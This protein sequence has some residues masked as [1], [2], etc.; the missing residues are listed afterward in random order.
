MSCHIISYHMASYRIVMG[1]DEQGARG[2]V[3]ATKKCPEWA[4]CLVPASTAFFFRVFWEQPIIPMAHD[5]TGCSHG[6]CWH[7]SRVNHAEMIAT[8]QSGHKGS[9]LMF[10]TRMCSAGLHP[11]ATSQSGHKGSVTFWAPLGQSSGCNILGSPG[12]VEWMPRMA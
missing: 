1:T 2:I 7:L 8:R 12:A 9:F 6:T 5:G 10:S 3:D 4:V 11:H